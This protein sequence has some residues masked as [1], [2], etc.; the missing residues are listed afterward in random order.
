MLYGNPKKDCNWV[1][2]DA[3]SRCTKKLNGKQLHEYCPVICNTCPDGLNIPC[4]DDPTF[5]FRNESDKDCEWVRR[6]TEKRCSKEWMGSELR[7]FCPSACDSCPTT[8]EKSYNDGDNNGD[9]IIL[10]TATGGSSRR[11]RGRK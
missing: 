2:K 5:F 4:M 1:G 9:I 3:K 8:T 6:N 7:T 11:L 10:P